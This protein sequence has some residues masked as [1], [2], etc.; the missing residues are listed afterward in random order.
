MVLVRFNHDAQNELER[1]RVLHKGVEYLASNVQFS[2][3]TNTS[4]DIVTLSDGSETIKYHIR[5][6]KYKAVLRQVKADGE[7]TFL[8]K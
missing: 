8:I 2:C 6:E 3:P 4:K 1:W 5:A 7:V